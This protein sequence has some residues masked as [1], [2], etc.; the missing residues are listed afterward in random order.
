MRSMRSV[1]GWLL[2][3]VVI[4]MSTLPTVASIIEIDI[5]GTTISVDSQYMVSESAL[6]S[7]FQWI[8]GMD[9]AEEFLFSVP[10]DNIANHIPGYIT[11]GSG[12]V[13]NDILVR[14]VPLKGR[15]RQSQWSLE[16]A[17]EAWSGVSS[18]TERIIDHDANLGAFK[19]YRK[20]EFPYSWQLFRKD[21]REAGLESIDSNWIASCLQMSKIDEE[22]P[23]VRCRTRLMIGDIGLEFSFNGKN[24]LFIESIKSYIVTLMRKWGN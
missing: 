12:D 11:K 3:F 16:N 21:P 17:P 22:G 9:R 24:L 10:A 2:P 19:V 8:P 13:K 14:A 7:I 15:M 1:I 6:S 23:V 18:Y 20:G 4:C 5:D